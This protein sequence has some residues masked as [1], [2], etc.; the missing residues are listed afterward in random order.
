MKKTGLLTYHNTF[1]A[2]ASLQTYA[3][4][5]MIKEKLKK[6][7][8]VNYTPLNGFVK[9]YKT[10]II[11]R[12]P[13][14]GLKSILEK[15][16]WVEKYLNLS[17]ASLISNDFEK[18]TSLLRDYDVLFVGSD[19]VFEV[20]PKG[21]AFAPVQP[22]IYYFP[23][24]VKAKKFSI[25]ASADKSDFSL[26]NAEQ[27]SYMRKSL[28]TMEKVSVR[29]EFTQ[30]FVSSISDVKAELIFD[31]TFSI[32][33]PETLVSEKVKK[34]GRFAVLN[35]ANRNLGEM[36]AMELKKRGLVIV[37]PNRSNYADINLMGK[38]DPMEWAEL[39]KYA[40]LTITDRF[41]GTIFSLKHS[42][43]VLSV[44]DAVE[45]KTQV[46]KKN[47]MLSR[48][49]LESLLLGYEEVQKLNAENLSKRI[50]VLLSEW[51][52]DN[53]MKKII[54]AKQVND[55]FMDGLSFG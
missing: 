18:A 46:S 37:S 15:K 24:E 31:P 9:E 14:S 30:D 45:Y 7:E 28:E 34:I 38:L 6:V 33:F 5:E 12:K 51:D 19:T 1:N 2:G 48:L 42:C 40:E 35:V 3:A 26:L 13:F 11:T 41:H 36:A 4:Q 43:P 21:K 10:R 32:A 44:D 54:E 52:G 22:N 49:G 29:D 17:N 23:E 55:N 16:R 47:D 8:I 50:D 20:R 25:A 27:I 53:I 39:Y